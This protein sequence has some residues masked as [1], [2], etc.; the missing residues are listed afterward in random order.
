MMHQFLLVGLAVAKERGIWRGEGQGGD[1][2]RETK[3][4]KGAPY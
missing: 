4:W 1:S 2:H 3:H